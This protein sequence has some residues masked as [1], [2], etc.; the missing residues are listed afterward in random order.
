MTIESKIY[1]PN[2]SASLISILVGSFFLILPFFYFTF[3]FPF[4]WFPSLSLSLSFSLSISLFRS[5]FL[6][7]F[8]L[9]FLSSYFL[10]KQMGL[11]SFVI[12]WLCHRKRHKEWRR[13]H[14]KRRERRWFAW[15]RGL[16]RE[17][18]RERSDPDTQE[19]IRIHPTLCTWLCLI[20]LFTGRCCMCMSWLLQ[21][22]HI[23][24]VSRVHKKNHMPLVPMSRWKKAKAKFGLKFASMSL[25][26]D[27]WIDVWCGTHCIT[28]QI[29]TEFKVFFIHL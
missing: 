22:S 27:D 14:A 12:T 16:E 20:I 24:T 25:Q 5:L 11:H 1:V 17:R 18:E 6:L 8:S 23:Q 29:H 2:V 9:S 10:A 21:Q 19:S 26:V 4:A 3:S 28:E 13:N 15:K 7:H